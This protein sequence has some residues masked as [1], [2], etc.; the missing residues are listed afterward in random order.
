MS[1]LSCPHHYKNKHYKNHQKSLLNAAST[2]SPAKATTITSATNVTA[3]PIITGGKVV[4]QTTFS[5]NVSPCD[6]STNILENSKSLH[7]IINSISSNKANLNDLF[8][9]TK[10]SPLGKITK[11]NTIIAPVTVLKM[12]IMAIRNGGDLP[13]DINNIANVIISNTLNADVNNSNTYTT[14]KST[15]SGKEIFSI[16]N[17]PTGGKIKTTTHI[18]TIPTGATIFVRNKHRHSRI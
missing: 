9:I 16:T 6:I 12:A 15:P 2:S 11:T 5:G 3:T 10:S 13:P 18:N 1:N 14:T 8:T 4:S 7:K 17:T